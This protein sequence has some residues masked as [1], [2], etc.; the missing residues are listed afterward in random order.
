MWIVWHGNAGDAYEAR[1]KG[2]SVWLENP[3]GKW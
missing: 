1:Y 3:K 2:W